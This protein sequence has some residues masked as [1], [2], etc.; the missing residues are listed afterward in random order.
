M[1]DES[2]GTNRDDVDD[3]V[4]RVRMEVVNEENEDDKD[5]D[6]M[7]G[8]GNDDDVSVMMSVGKHNY[9]SPR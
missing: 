2:E 8:D 5:G 3:F 6:M 7:M 4:T 1:V 9:L